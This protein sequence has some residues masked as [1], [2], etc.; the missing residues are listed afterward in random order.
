MRMGECRTHRISLPIVAA[1][2][3]VLAAF[4]VCVHGQSSAPAQD[5]TP[6]CTTPDCREDITVSLFTGSSIDSFAASDL[7]K[8]LNPQASGNVQEQLV[9][10][11]DFSLRVVGSKEKPERPQVWL[12][13]ETVHGVRSGDVDCAKNENA[14]LCRSLNFKPPSDPASAAPSIAIFRKSTSFEGFFGLRAEL[15]Q[16]RPDSEGAT[17]RLYVKGQLGFLTV[18]NNGDDVI[19]M[20]H[21]ALGIVMSRGLLQ[22]SYVEMGYGRNDVFSDRHS[23]FKVDAMMSLDINK[24]IT[25]FAQIVVDADFGGRPDSIRS[26]F[27]FDINVKELF[28]P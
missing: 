7:K 22:D 24:P 28:K 23:R 18:A 20:H 13:G 3:A 5:K 10:G 19:D 1:V 2:A 6:A 15:L 14:E 27:G 12:Y 11:F 8:Y 9:A 4:P 16:L 21:V 26:Y 25:P 17:S